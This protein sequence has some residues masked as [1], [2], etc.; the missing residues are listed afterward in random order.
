MKLDATVRVALPEGVPFERYQAEVRRRISDGAFD[1]L[2]MVP[3]SDTD[4]HFTPDEDSEEGGGG[5]HAEPGAAPE[6]S[7]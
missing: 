5:P 4:D 1:L 7:E 2:S 6:V 3:V